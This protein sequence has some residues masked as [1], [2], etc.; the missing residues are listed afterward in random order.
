M[1]K[2]LIARTAV[3]Y[4][5]SEYDEYIVESPLLDGCSGIGETEEEAHRLFSNLLDDAY[6]AYLEGTM[7]EYD[8][9]G[10]PSKGRLALNTDVLPKTRKGIKGLVSDFGCSQ[11]ELLD[12]LY[13]FYQASMETS[14]AKLDQEPLQEKLLTAS[15]TLTESQAKQL[16]KSVNFDTNKRQRKKSS[17]AKSRTA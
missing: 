16:L 3:C 12:F 11:G 7:A 14:K 10:R 6:E 4:L 8:K 1:N 17:R 2:Q 9:P 15:V 13:A 5:S